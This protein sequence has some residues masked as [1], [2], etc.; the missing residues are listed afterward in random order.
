M[1]GQP[2]PGE[3][4]L[5]RELFAPLAADEPGALGL[6][7]DAA[8]IAPA[9][10]LELVTAIDTIVE[11]VHFLSG[12]PAFDV[13][14][15]LLRVNLSDLAA[16]GAR[17]RAY[18]LGLAIPES[19]GFDWLREFARGLSSDQAQFGISLV[20]GDTT[21]TGGP[22]C[23]S[24]T[25][26]GEAEPGKA[27][28]RSNAVAGEHIYVSGT[29]GDAALGLRALRGEA[30]GLAES[31]LEALVARYRVPEPRLDLGWLLPDGAAIDVSDG[32]IA[33]IGHVCAASGLGATIE[34]DR[35]PLS[36]AARRALERGSVEIAD[37][38]TGGDDYE[39]VFTA[40]ADRG[41]AIREA[42]AKARVP[43]ARIGS[44]TEGAAISVVD[45]SGAPIR[46][47]DTG[48]RHF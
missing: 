8:L 42:S 48:Y 19:V 28:L 35:V 13:A 2:R 27:K 45:S 21:A 36:G 25:V 7:D 22:P 31:D 11:G 37:L 29:V 34:A 3:F 14:R 16:M 40:P 20:G 24:L 1:P 17:P 32:L 41:G 30:L 4:E 18:L 39:L 33:D 23:F 12:D 5:V 9:P 6:L 47:G 26:I 15:K 43:V 46:I 10:G 44:M 38:L